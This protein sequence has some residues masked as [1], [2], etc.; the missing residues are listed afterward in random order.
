LRILYTTL[1]YLLTPAILLRL[2]WRGR[3]APAYR[4]RWAERFGCLPPLLATHRDSLWIHAV[5]VGEAQAAIP[6]VK[7]LQQRFPEQAILITTMTPTGSARVQAAFGKQVT[8]VY[9]PYDLPDAIARFLQGTQPR[10]LILMETELWPNLL[11]ACR[12]R[13]LPVLLA[14]ARLSA[15]S[16]RGYQRFAALTRPMLRC[17]THIAAQTETDA[18]RFLA[19]GAVAEQI[20]VTGSIKFDLALPADIHAHAQQLRTQWQVQRPVWIAA[21]THAGEEAQLLTALTIVQQT[22]PEVLLILV[23]R[24][25]ERFAAVAELCMDMGFTIARRSQGEIPASNTAIYLGDTMGELLLLYAASDVAF[26]GGSLVPTGGHNPLEPA[27]L[28]IPVLVGTHTFNFAE[29]NAK[30]IALG[31]AIRVQNS[32]TLAQAVLHYLQNPQA[33]QQAGDQGKQF[34]EAN[35][36]ALGRLL[37]IITTVISTD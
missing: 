21:S 33:S 9:L 22:L 2:W 5:S 16:A 32:I 15:R 25:P 12:R 23:P 29:I 18:H 17:L 35:R 6:L 3:R 30:L 14:N 27:A 10:A 24:H 19:C 13:H 11:H 34:V 8:H 7:Q 28:Q 1:L 4:Q 31:A 26:V 20:T 36:G 37:A